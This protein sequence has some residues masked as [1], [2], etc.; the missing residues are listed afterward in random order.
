VL[1]QRKSELVRVNLWD[2]TSSLCSRYSDSC[3][4]TQFVSLQHVSTLNIYAVVIHAV[5]RIFYNPTKRLQYETK[6]RTVLIMNNKMQL[7]LTHELPS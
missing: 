6:L 3:I 5:S 1:V 7:I 4:E 2:E